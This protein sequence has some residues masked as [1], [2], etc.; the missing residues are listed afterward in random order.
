MKKA[1]EKIIKRIEIAGF[2]FCWYRE[3]GV[4]YGNQ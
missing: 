3:F 2:A 1:R 4:H